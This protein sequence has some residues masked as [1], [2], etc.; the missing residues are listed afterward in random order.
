MPANKT[1]NDP[2]KLGARPG[3]CLC[4][5]E[6]GEAS[7]AEEA[8]GIQKQMLELTVSDAPLQL[9]LDG[10]SQ[11]V[12]CQSPG[13][14][15]AILLLDADG[16]H[17]RRATAPS[18]S[19]AY[20]CGKGLAVAEGACSCGS[21]AFRR[22]AAIAEDIATDPAWAD[23]RHLALADGLRVCRAYPILDATG[24][25]LGTFAIHY[26]LTARPTP[27]H[28]SL[29]NLATHLAAIAIARQRE[30]NALGH[31]PE[32]AQAVLVPSV[33]KQALETS[34]C[35]LRERFAAL[36]GREREVLAL[37]LAGHANKEIGKR[38]G[39]SVR[40]VEH[41]RTHILLKTGTENLLRLVCLLNIGQ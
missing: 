14:Q 21:A 31:P 29:V 9:T 28:R 19:A 33:A 1:G 12:E 3:Q 5:E 41:H 20:P 30:E 26:P 37:A 40:T 22:E 25:V 34:D 32:S 17:L 39:I 4:V 35:A 38:L 27:F 13:I 2:G 10:L 16:R 15:V 24:D 6:R 23:C 7:E 8:L 11:M 18:L 36:T